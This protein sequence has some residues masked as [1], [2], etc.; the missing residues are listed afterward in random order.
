MTFRFKNDK[1]QQ[2]TDAAPVFM[3]LFQGTKQALIALATY[4]HQL[5]NPNDPLAACYVSRAVRCTVRHVQNTWQAMTAMGIMR[6]EGERAMEDGKY[7]HK[8]KVRIVD[9][10]TARRLADEKRAKY[11]HPE[12]EPGYF[13]KRKIDRDNAERARNQRNMS[14]MTKALSELDVNDQQSKIAYARARKI[15]AIDGWFFYDLPHKPIFSKRLPIEDEP[16]TYD[17]VCR[18]I[19]ADAAIA[20]AKTKMNA[21][22]ARAKAYKDTPKTLREHFETA[23]KDVK[24]RYELEDAQVSLFFQK[25]HKQTANDTGEIFHN[26]SLDSIANH[27]EQ[28]ARLKGKRK[29][30]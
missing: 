19:A 11:D 18:M 14:F 10:A 28:F 21:A 26:G 20:T 13:E 17:E 27:L 5:L 23:L 2:V 15:R 29:P 3:T 6:S 9:P 7:W 24:T 22:A 4:K 1:Y 25:I 8:P 12:F 16:R 30:V